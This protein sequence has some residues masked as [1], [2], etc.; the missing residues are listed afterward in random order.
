MCVCAPAQVYTRDIIDRYNALSSDII[1]I[2]S[3]MPLDLL[4]SIDDEN[5]S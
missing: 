3:S 1:S 2:L 4:V 5:T